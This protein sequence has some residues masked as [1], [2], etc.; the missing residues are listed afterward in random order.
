M[1]SKSWIL[2]GLAAGL[3]LVGA[4]AVLLTPSIF[5]SLIGH[6]TPRSTGA[7]RAVV[8]V[9]GS[10]LAGTVAAITAARAAAGGV[11]VVVLEKEERTGGN[12]AKAS[13]GINALS[14]EA[15]DFAELFRSDTLQ[16]GSNVNAAGLV[17]VLVVSATL[18]TLTSCVGRPSGWRRGGAPCCSAS[19]AALLSGGEQAGPGFPGRVW[20]GFEQQRAAWGAQLPAD[21]RQHQRP[22]RRLLHHQQAG[23]A[24]VPAQ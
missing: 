24:P 9:V 5:S 19:S 21:A 15:G 4:I 13:S 16:A 17:D 11:D 8:V 10:G 18:K 6:L 3:A 7:S 22:Q 12:S 2:G 14:P 23:G 20:T 1:S